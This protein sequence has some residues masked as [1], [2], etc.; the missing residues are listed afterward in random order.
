MEFTEYPHRSRK[1]SSCPA[2]CRQLANKL[3][4]EPA[5]HTGQGVAGNVWYPYIKSRCYV[6]FQQ[7]M[8]LMQMQTPSGLSANCRPRMM[9]ATRPHDQRARQAGGRFSKP[10]G[11]LRRHCL[12]WTPILTALGFFPLPA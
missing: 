5:K 9:N 1:I 7:S 12:P 2:I 8:H 6:P 3:F 11:P 10:R 4:V